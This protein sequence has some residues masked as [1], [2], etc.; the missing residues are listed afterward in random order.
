MKKFQILLFSLFLVFFLVGTGTSATIPWVYSPYDNGETLAFGDSD[1]LTINW[2][3]TYGGVDLS[4]QQAQG[5]YGAGFIMSGSAITFDADL[6]TYDS[7]SDPTGAA[8]NDGWWDAFVVNINQVG[9]YW[10]LVEGGSGAITDPIVDSS[11]AGGTPTFDN[12]VLPGVTWVWG[13][14]DWGVNSLE[15]FQTSSNDIYLGL[16]SYDPTKPVYVSLVLDTATQPTQDTNY[17]SGGKFQ[18]YPVPE[19]AY[20]LLLGT[21]LVG[22]AGL[23]RKKLMKK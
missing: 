3:G 19:P 9:Y 6:G 5:I 15:T 22:L 2:D 4:A 11:Y 7:Y 10:E 23:G 20:M 18:V 8:G 1:I 17:L 14:V 12:S 21:C 16:S 13:G